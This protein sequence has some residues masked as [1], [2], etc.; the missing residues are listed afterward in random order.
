MSNVPV[1]L[2]SAAAGVPLI[3]TKR[4]RL[5]YSTVAK[6]D[7][8]KKVVKIHT[9][10][11]PD[12]IKISKKRQQNG[13]YRFEITSKCTNSNF[14]KKPDID[15]LEKVLKTRARFDMHKNSRQKQLKIT[16]KQPI[17][18]EKLTFCTYNIRGIKGCQYE[19]NEL[20]RV[21]QPTV[22]AVQETLLNKKSYRYKLPGYTVIE[23]KSDQNLGGNG[24]FIDLKNNSGLQIFELKQHPHW[25]S[26]KKIGKTTDGN[27]FTVIIINLH[28]PS[29]GKRKKDAILT[30]NRHIQKITDNKKH[31]KIIVLGDFNMDKSKYNGMNMGRMIDHILYSGMGE[32]LNYCKVSHTVDLKISLKIIEKHANMLLNHNRFAVLTANNAELGALCNDTATT[33]TDT[34]P[35]VTDNCINNNPKELWN[36]IKFRT[37]KNRQFI[38]NGPVLDKNK[39]LIT[40]SKQKLNVWAKNFGNLAKDGT[41]N[42]QNKAKWTGVFT[43]TT[44]A[45]NICESNI[46]WG[47]IVTALKGT[48]NNKASDTDIIPSKVWKLVQ[49]EDE[50]E[51]NLAKLILKLAN[52]IYT[53]D[54][55]PTI[56]TSSIVVPVPKKGD[57]NDPNNY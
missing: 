14:F 29:T 7:S 19:F 54:G 53:S 33:I 2:P 36:W 30:L 1:V 16:K 44:N 57:L 15:L 38:S 40:D 5:E 48:P 42:S 43:N 8:V 34:N 18:N 39:S 45:F 49:S 37:G 52:K 25:M 26:A 27:K 32:R 55:I 22:V 11:C 6:T 21:R 24:L 28:F 3:P 41:G 47:E 4:T 31:Q 46:N 35:N 50:P 12:S 13:E 23:S 17:V 20:M 56:W 10:I 51:S 9:K